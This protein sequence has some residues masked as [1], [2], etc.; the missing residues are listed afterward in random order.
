MLTDRV[1]PHNL[2]AERAA[3][4][5]VLRDARTYPIVASVLAVDDFFRDAHK[6]V[7]ARMT[8]LYERGVE[9]D[10]LTLVDD[11]QR[12]GELEEAGGAAYVSAMTDGVPRASNVEH[13]A[14]IVLEKSR[15][16]KIIKTATDAMSDAYAT[17]QDAARVI[18]ETVSR[19]LTVAASVSGGSVSL[20]VAIGIYLSALMS[21][22]NA[23]VVPVGLRDVDDIAGGF[24]RRKLSV[25]AARPS[26]GKTSLLSHSAV[27]AAA[28]GTPV[29]IFSLEVEPA[30]LAGGILAAASRVSGDRMRKGTATDDEVAR[31][32]AARG[33]LAGLPIYVVTEA[34]TLTQIAA[35]TRR[36][37]E[38]YG[39][40]I[41]FLDYLQLLGD[42]NSKNRQQE[43]AGFSRGL[44]RLAMT[45]DV[46]VVALAQL[47]RNQERRQDRRP[48]LSDLRESGAIEA[49]ADLC[50]LLHR[51]ELHDPKEENHGIAEIIVAKNRHGPV[52]CSRVAFI[53]DHVRFADLF[54]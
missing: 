18:D 15:L 25:I 51:E 6:L 52:G 46:A 10:L 53:A 22:E 32:T 28:S 33:D 34:T 40:R 16:R 47:N 44:K 43:V 48:Q 54:I 11:L 23:D 2:D 24:M 17:E 49:D 3:L 29:G 45:E 41:V 39:V 30:A 26:V 12:V 38:S 20:D 42:P 7:F 13:Y 36:L 9:I 50:L 5:S 4:G 37:R 31:V 1:L 8:S 19:L 35:W 21:S 27:S 14:R